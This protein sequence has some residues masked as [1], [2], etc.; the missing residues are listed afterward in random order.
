MQ[1]GE[2][3]KAARTAKGMTQRDVGLA[4]G[5]EAQNP[6]NWI[7]LYERGEATPE[8]K[9]F[10]RIV[11]VLDLDHDQAWSAYGRACARDA[12]RALLNGE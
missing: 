11:E 12:A 1:L 10:V 6:G 3:L 9:A 4:I 7:G 2:M 8:R 5:S